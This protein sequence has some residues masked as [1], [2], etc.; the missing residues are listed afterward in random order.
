MTIADGPSAMS[1]FKAQRDQMVETQIAA[2]GVHDA[3]D[4]YDYEEL[5]PVAF[6]P[7]IGAQGWEPGFT[8]PP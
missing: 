6:V 2:R 4:K 7:L 8:T 1:D 5:E 3:E